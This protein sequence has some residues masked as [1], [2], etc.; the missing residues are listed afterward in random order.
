MKCRDISKCFK[1]VNA[2][3]ILELIKL[4][5]VY[6]I[7]QTMV[8]YI[9]GK[10]I[11]GVLHLTNLL[12]H[13]MKLKEKI[14]YQTL[15]HGVNVN[16]K[17]KINGFQP[18]NLKVINSIIRTQLYLFLCVLLPVFVYSN[19]HFLIKTIRQNII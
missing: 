13:I 14:E 5:L 10:Y 7:L 1:M 9:M 19:Q 12:R 3:D 18:I 4:G 6:M 17:Y 8:S 15:T 11:K 2:Y 16:V